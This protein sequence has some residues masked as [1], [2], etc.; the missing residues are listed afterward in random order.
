MRRFL[1]KFKSSSD[2]SQKTKSTKHQMLGQLMR[3][4]SEALS[5]S[6]AG[7]GLGHLNTDSITSA[8]VYYKEKPEIEQ[9]SNREIA[10]AEK[11]SHHFQFF[12]QRQDFGLPSASIFDDGH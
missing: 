2:Y 3:R 4:K 11:K 8:A 7:T 9:E 12:W 1:T 10:R 5:D 6:R